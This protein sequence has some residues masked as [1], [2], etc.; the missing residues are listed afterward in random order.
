MQTN[1][2]ALTT[3]SEEDNLHH[4]I[5][6]TRNAISPIEM[7]VVPEALDGQNGTNRG[8][9]DMAQIGATNDLD[10][11]RAWL[12]NYADSRNTSFDSYRKEAERLLL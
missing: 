4:A 5:H 6:R 10:A 7:L 9:P 8:A 1:E 11:V 2:C 12:A 3:R